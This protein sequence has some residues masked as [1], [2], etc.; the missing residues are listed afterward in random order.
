MYF[1]II[2][3]RLEQIQNEKITMTISRKGLELQIIWYFIKYFSFR[4]HLF[5]AQITS[6]IAIEWRAL[7]AKRNDKAYNEYEY[8][9]DIKCLPLYMSIHHS[10]FAIHMCVK[11]NLDAEMLNQS[12]CYVQFEIPSILMI[13][14]EMNVLNDDAYENTEMWSLQLNHK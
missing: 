7:N 9:Y 3:R 4:M 8:E 5:V 14:N 13:W 1:S 10:P 6:F 12:V 2:E 11:Y